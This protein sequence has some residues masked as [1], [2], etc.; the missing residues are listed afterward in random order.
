MITSVFGATYLMWRQMS[1]PLLGGMN[2]S[3]T[4]TSGCSLAMVS[5]QG[6]AVRYAA[7]HLARGRKQPLEGDQKVCV[8]I[9]HQHSRSRGSHLHTHTFRKDIHSHGEALNR[10]C[11][12][13]DAT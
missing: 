3:T 10:Y 5:K 7:H 13:A 12:L 1:S 9:G 6:V 8:V 11:L 4:I 2:R